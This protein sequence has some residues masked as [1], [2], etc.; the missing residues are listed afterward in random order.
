MRKCATLV[1][2]L[3]PKLL[4]FLSLSLSLLLLVLVCLRARNSDCDWPCETHS[5]RFSGPTQT[6][7]YRIG[8]SIIERRLA[9]LGEQNG[10][11]VRAPNPKPKGCCR[12]G[13]AAD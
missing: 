4:P 13:L 9:H 12:L 10:D 1:A 5:L 11:Q 3:M 8:L 7:A 6:T 2:A